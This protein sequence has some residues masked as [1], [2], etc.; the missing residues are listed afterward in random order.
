VAELRQPEIDPRIR[1]LLRGATDEAAHPNGAGAA[2]ASQATDG[3]A[4]H[5]LDL[6]DQPTI[7]DLRTDSV[8]PA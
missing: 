2:G 6:A 4:A 7:T 1:P 3:A 5:D 8:P